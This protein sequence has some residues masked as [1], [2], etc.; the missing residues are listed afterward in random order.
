[1]EEQ[2][3]NYEKKH[4]LEIRPSVSLANNIKRKDPVFQLLNRE[5]VEAVCAQFF[6][7]DCAQ[8][9]DVE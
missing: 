4:T 6:D 5:I 1:M 2:L 9:F 3:E 8:F 7:V